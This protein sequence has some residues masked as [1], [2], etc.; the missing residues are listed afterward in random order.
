VNNN[1]RN[2]VMAILLSAL[3]LF[4]WGLISPILFPQ[5]KPVATAPAVPGQPAAPVSA[6]AQ[7]TRDRTVVLGES[8][9]IAID[10]PRLKGSI[11]LKGARIDDLVLPTYQE[12]IAKD[13][14]PVKLFTPEGAKQSYFTGF[15]WSGTG[16]ALPDANTV[17]TADGTTLTPDTPVTMTWSNLTGQSFVIKIAVDKDFLFTVTQTVSNAGAAA[18]SARSYAYVSRNHVSDEPSSWTNH[19][20]PMGVFD[21]VAN[22]K[23]NFT[24]MDEAG[25]TGERFPAK[26]GWLGFGDKYW[27]AA[28]VLPGNAAAETWFRADRGTYH[29]EAV[30]PQ[31]NVAPGTSAT[32][33]QHIFAGAKEVELLDHYAENGSVPLLGKAIDWGWFEIIAKPFFTMLHWLFQLT[34]N[35]GVAIILMTFIVRGFMFPIAQRQFASMAAMK[36][37][38]PKMKA[39]QE[40]FKDDKVKQQQ[41]IME[42]YKKEKVNPLAGCLPIVLQIPVFYALYKVLILAIEMRHQPFV[43]WLHDLSAPDKLTPVNLFGYL[44]FTPPSMLALGVLPI[45]LGITM[46][47]Q[48]K[49]NPQQGDPAQQQIFAI[50]PW[51]FMFIMAGF[52]SGLQLYW[53]VSNI[54]TIAQQKW[55]YSK[56]PALKAAPVPAK[57]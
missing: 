43:L 18:V 26:N 33:T 25:T 10:T 23:V 47:L 27:L 36:I 22:Y 15:G 49:L 29:A 11:N 41:E 20:G 50:M 54:L 31:T 9:R 14:P 32:V 8:P 13:S 19:I 52:A 56:H 46:Y 57:T 12:T 37:L 5:P 2:M 4:G 48:F 30:M 53:T 45:L 28:L 40:R 24:D 42:L 38:Q 21:G 7:V 39:I 17:W 55:L 34:H 35:F 51:L 6:P 44:P 16:L 3:V 1:N